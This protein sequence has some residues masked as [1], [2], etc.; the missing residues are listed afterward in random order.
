MKYRTIAT[1][2]THLNTIVGEGIITT[3]P[4]VGYEAKRPEREQ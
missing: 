3:T 2:T 4:C 1:L